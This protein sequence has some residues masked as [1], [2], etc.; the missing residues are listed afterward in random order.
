MI[1]R[2]A[3]ILK[4]KQP[5]VDWINATDPVK[6]KPSLT[7]EEVNEDRTVYLIQD[8]QA[9]DP[10]V[11]EVWLRLNVE[12]L[13]E[14]EISG[15]YQDDSLWPKNLNYKLFQSWFDVECHTVIIDTGENEIIDDEA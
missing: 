5:A 4:Y 8:E 11:L 10:D 1:N 3:L 6:G 7:V 9:D 12:A 2:A 15:W 13:F 14:D